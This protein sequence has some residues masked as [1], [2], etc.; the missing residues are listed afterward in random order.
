MRFHKVETLCGWYSFLLGLTKCWHGSQVQTEGLSGTKQFRDHGSRGAAQSA[1]LSVNPAA[2]ATIPT[3]AF[4]VDGNARIDDHIGIGMNPDTSEGSLQTNGAIQYLD[5]VITFTNDFTLVGNIYDCGGQKYFL[6][7]ASNKTIT[8]PESAARGCH[9]WFTSPSDG[10][11]GSIT[12]QAQGSDTVNGTSS[13]SRGVDNS[14]NHAICFNTG[15]WVV[16]NE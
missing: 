13:V 15:E 14:I 12:I 8:L 9:F 1:Y 4:T 11:G 3:D 16:G 7:S 6:L 2:Y 5:D 10:G